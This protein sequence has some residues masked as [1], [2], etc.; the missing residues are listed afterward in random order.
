MTTTRALWGQVRDAEQAENRRHQQGQR[1]KQDAGEYL[2]EGRISRL[3]YD[4]VIHGDIT[5][6]R[7]LDIGTDGEEL[8]DTTE[9]YN[10]RRPEGGYQQRPGTCL[11]GCGDRPSKS[12]SRFLPGHDARMRRLARRYLDADTDLSDPQLNYVVEMGYFD[13]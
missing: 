9:T 5:L 8:V 3:A 11:C 1:N 10:V 4:A 13:E 2:R 12:R 7:A 6:E